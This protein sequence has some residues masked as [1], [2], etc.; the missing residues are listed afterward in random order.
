MSVFDSSSRLSVR[1]SGNL[2][3][4]NRQGQRGPSFLSVASISINSF[5]G[6]RF[7][8][9]Q[10]PYFQRFRK[11]TE[12]HL[13]RPLVADLAFVNLVT[14]FKF[15]FDYLWGKSLLSSSQIITDHRPCAG[16]QSGRRG[17]W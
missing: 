16:R 6:K 1:K 13:G 15:I 11:R 17:G 12:G 14:E 9:N 10:Q 5:P 2:Q 7:F 8:C 3:M 4:L